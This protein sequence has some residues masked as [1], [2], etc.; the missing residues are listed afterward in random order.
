MAN[1]KDIAKLAGVSVTTVSR[2]I[3]G[4][5]YVST[6]KKE[7]VQ[8]AMEMENY[9]RNINAV[10]LSKGK[11]NLIGVVVPSIRRPYFGMVVEGI[12]DEAIKD[13]YKLVLI[14]TNYEVEREM[15]ALMMLKLKQIDALIICSKTSGWD[16]VEE[17]I[18]YG[19]IIILE[20]AR[21]TKLS[22]IFIDH[23]QIFSNALAY[24][25]SKGHHKIGYCLAR[26]SSPNSARREAAYR[27][28]YTNLQ[29]DYDPN[30]IF[31]DCVHLEDG[32]WIMQ[33][34]VGMEDPPTALLVTSDQ[35]AAGILTYCQENNI[36]VPEDLAIVGFDNQPIA[37]VLHI[38]TFE[39]PI[40]EIGRK[41]FLK[42]IDGSHSHEEIP[43]HL[44]ERLTV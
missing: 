10:H 28:F 39:I 9:E 12:A 38:T 44:I 6:L 41:L 36:R 11:T 34:I 25:R 15:D 20:D 19:P 1:I 13:N 23:Y 2:V 3:N 29:E 30:Y 37:K 31:Y 35:V 33:R 40:V 22:S 27:D 5:P 16:V 42:A 21:G 26:R 8:R 4:H 32:E 43:I 24:L 17:Y 18:Q 7:A 14:Q